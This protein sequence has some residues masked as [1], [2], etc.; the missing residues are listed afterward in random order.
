MIPGLPAGATI[1]SNPYGND[2]AAMMGAMPRFHWTPEWAA[3]AAAAAAAQPQ[4]A[5][6]GPYGGYINIGE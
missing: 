4:Q 1:I 3:A 6:A 5:M 2:Y